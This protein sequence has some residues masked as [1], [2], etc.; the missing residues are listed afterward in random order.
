M[1]S[2]LKWIKEGQHSMLKVDRGQAPGV[3]G[4]LTVHR[5]TPSTQ[6]GSANAVA[7][8]TVAGAGRGA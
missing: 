7:W 4:R 8:W 1:Q 3:S 2:R 5:R 6:D